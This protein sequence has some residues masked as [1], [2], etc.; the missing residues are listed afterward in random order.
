MAL[1]ILSSPPPDPEETADQLR[2]AIAS[3]LPGATIRV[4]AASP[5]HFEVSVVSR[6]FEGKPKVRQQQMVYQAI[7]GFMSGDEP[8]VHAIDRMETRTS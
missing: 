7:G 1:K 4:S 3:E 5:G 6:A 2:C 8:L